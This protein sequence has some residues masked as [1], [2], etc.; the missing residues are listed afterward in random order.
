MHSIGIVLDVYG[1]WCRQYTA[2]AEISAMWQSRDYE[3]VYV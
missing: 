2:G 3:K 1:M